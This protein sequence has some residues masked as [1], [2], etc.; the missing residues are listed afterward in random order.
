VIGDEVSEE[1]NRA[2]IFWLRN[3]VFERYGAPSR[4]EAPDTGIQYFYSRH[5]GS[6]RMI[7]I[8]FNVKDGMVT[9]VW[10]Q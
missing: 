6:D 8:A 4:L 1:L 5:F 9:Y 2:H 3:E 10:A 7:E